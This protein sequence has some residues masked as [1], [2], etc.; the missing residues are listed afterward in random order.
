MFI[1]IFSSF[2]FPLIDINCD[3]F[4]VTLSMADKSESITAKVGENANININ[5]PKISATI[6]KESFN[7]IA[8]AISSAGGATAGLKTAQYVGGTPATKLLVGIGTMA[9]VQAT[10][11]GM[12]KILNHNT[13]NNNKGNNLVNYLIN[14]SDSNDSSNILNDYPLNLLV[15]IDLLLYAAILFLFVFFNIYLANY[16]TQINY[17]KYLPKNKIGNFL[18]KFISRYIKIWSKSKEILLIISWILLLISIVISKFFLHI[19]I[20]F[21]N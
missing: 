4:D 7:T 14:N 19:I 3:I 15:E 11:A 5:N 21:Y 20:N 10:T 6:G 18:N 12:S 13:N 17:S 16:I 9:I 2:N 8:A 1:L